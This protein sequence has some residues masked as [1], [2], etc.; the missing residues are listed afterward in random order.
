MIDPIKYSID[1]IILNYNSHSIV[2]KF[3]LTDKMY[4]NSEI[5]ACL[6]EYCRDY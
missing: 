5:I 1:K 2:W 6:L 4:D 3:A